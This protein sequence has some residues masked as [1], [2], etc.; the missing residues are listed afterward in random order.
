MN[1]QIDLNCLLFDINDSDYVFL[2]YGPL[3]VAVCHL[4]EFDDFADDL[5]CKIK[6]IRKEIKENY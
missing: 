4:D 6:D 5:I 1:K 2:C 3:R